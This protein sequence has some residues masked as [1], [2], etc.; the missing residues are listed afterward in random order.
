[1]TL[2]LPSAAFA[3]AVL[4]FDPVCAALTAYGSGAGGGEGDDFPIARALLYSILDPAALLAGHRVNDYILAPIEAARYLAFDFE[5]ET[6]TQTT[7]ALV[8]LANAGDQRRAFQL[9]DWI[10][11]QLF[12]RLP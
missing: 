8:A 6:F 3:I 5:A 2:A 10:P 7:R 4:T 1:M 9:H 11:E 12:E